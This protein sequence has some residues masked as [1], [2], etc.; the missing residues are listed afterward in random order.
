MHVV[1]P[2]RTTRYW[3]LAA[4]VGILDQIGPHIEQCMRQALPM[5]GRATLNRPGFPGDSRV[6][7]AHA[8]LAR[9]RRA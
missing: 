6:W 9:A 4:F 5:H 2:A 3:D 7:I 1:A 8:A